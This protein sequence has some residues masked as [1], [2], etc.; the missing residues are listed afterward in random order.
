MTKTDPHSIRAALRS[1]M[2]H[3]MKQRDGE[4]TAVYR[5]ALGAIDN[6]EAVPLGD[7]HR[8]GPVG[9][10]PTGMGRTEAEIAGRG[11]TV[12]ARCDGEGTTGSGRSVLYTD[13]PRSAGGGIQLTAPAGAWS[14]L[15]MSLTSSGERAPAGSTPDPSAN[16]PAS[17]NQT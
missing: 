17:G 13:S 7:Q 8:A 16:P 9:I 2:T 3:A 10:S 12:S 14:P 1:A 6:A 11:T 5:A 4:T 15:R